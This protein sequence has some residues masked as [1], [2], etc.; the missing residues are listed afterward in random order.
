MRDLLKSQEY[1]DEYIGEESGRVVKYER[2][3]ASGTLSSD[4]IIPVKCK[5]LSIRIE[6]LIARYS[7]GDSIDELKKEFISIVNTACEVWNFE[8]YDDNLRLL[9]LGVLFNIERE[10]IDMFSNLIMKNGEYDSI[11]E[12]ISS[13]SIPDNITLCYPDVYEEMWNT[14]QKNDPSKIS[15]YIKNKW[16]KC[17]H[18]S[19]WYDS[20]KSKEKLY[21]GYWAFEMAAL[22]KAL[23]IDAS[24]LR[25]TLHFPYD[26]YC[27]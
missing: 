15:E 23:N 16:Y 3:I 25:G 1:F 10:T 12:S 27:Y 6:M 22:M 19:Y 11:I 9:S 2:K 5:L 14:I 7:R 8:S 13:G 24:D 4:R 26:L 21:F 17:H 20:H 18:Y